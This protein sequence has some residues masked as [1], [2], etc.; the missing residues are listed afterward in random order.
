MRKQRA[1]ARALG[2]GGVAELL[3]ALEVEGA[4]AEDALLGRLVQP[5]PRVQLRW[6]CYRLTYILS[7][8]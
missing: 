4:E 2:D 1:R 8:F 7:S 5:P 3:V 6:T